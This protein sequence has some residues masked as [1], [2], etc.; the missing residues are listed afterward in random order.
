MPI[1]SYKPSYKDE[2]KNNEIPIQPDNYQG[3]VIDTDSIPISS[4]I[5]YIDGIP[6][7]TKAYYSQYLS[8]SND[9]RDL[10]TSQNPVYQQYT[11]INNLELRVTSSLEQSQ[12]P[13]NSTVTITGAANMFYHVIPNIGDLFIASTYHSE[14]TLFRVK[15]VSRLNFNKYTSWA[16]TYDVISFL[17]EN[18]TVYSDLEKKVINTLVFDKE[19]IEHNKTP[20]LSTEHA[21]QI[22]YLKNLY[23]YLVDY[24]LNTFFSKKYMTLVVPGQDVNIYD[25]YIV[26]FISRI[27]NVQDHK[28][29]TN[30]RKI[31]IGTD[32]TFKQP[33]IWDVLLSDHPNKFSLLLSV[34][35]KLS[36]ASVKQFMN[37]PSVQSLHYSGID[38]IL[39]PI[40]PD[41][42]VDVIGL[43]RT[44]N[45]NDEA[46]E[47][48]TSGILNSILPLDDNL[49]LD[50]VTNTSISIIKDT[51]IN[52]Y[53]V[54]SQD[55]YSQTGDYSLLEKMVTQY[56]KDEALS[57]NNLVILTDKHSHWNRLNQ[58]YYIPI[59]IAFI[60]LLINST[61][62]W[63]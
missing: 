58:Y 6:W 28:T 50:S 54:L 1:A 20:I 55:F 60:R 52:N 43:G 22:K 63:L 59:I 57:I 47:L 51:Y 41:M 49:L 62:T 13:N 16:I 42:S 24:Y 31:I 27:F 34:Q 19:L 12:D 25:P 38:N 44:I 5:S 53:Y 36:V 35:Q 15:E 48:T 9:L 14:D 11:K 33:V 26:N 23:S 4:L 21:S 29:L 37:Y 39:Y 18:P 2:A 30:M 40:T 32:D 61:Y 46:V 17:D 3:V 8:S 10:D 45:L 56:L 7:T